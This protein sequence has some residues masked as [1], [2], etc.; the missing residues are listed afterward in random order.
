MVN[1]DP[2]NILSAMRRHLQKGERITSVV[3]MSI[4]HS[5]E[6]YRLE[7]AGSRPANAA[8]AS[9]TRR[10]GPRYAGPVR[11]V[12]GIA[13]SPR[14]SAG[15]GGAIPV[16][17]R[18]PA[19]YAVLPDGGG[20]RRALQRMRSRAATDGS[21]RA[22]FTQQ[23]CEA[24]VSVDRQPPLDVLGAPLSITAELDRWR[25]V[26][27]AAGNNELVKHFGF[28]YANVPPLT[29]V[30]T[31][32]HGDPKPANCRGAMASSYHF[33]TGRCPSTA[34]RLGTLAT[35]SSFCPV[36]CTPD[37]WQLRPLRH[38][39]RRSTHRGLG[40]R[41]RTFCRPPFVVRGG[42][43]C[44]SRIVNRPRLP[45]SCQRYELR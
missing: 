5:N 31:L 37:P 21:R 43:P 38:V 16:R 24:I 9:R 7:G 15:T 40:G 12:C 19:R 3:P 13:W 36:T 26:A 42:L 2:K 28:L 33:W 34:T 32:V 20:Q 4:G 17:R 23:W 39:G 8:V 14:R 6:T 10:A 29:G 44:K 45:P 11:V 18:G 30:P 27:S 1:R 22:A 25:D 41:D 35:C